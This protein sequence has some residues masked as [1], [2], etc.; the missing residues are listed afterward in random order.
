MQGLRLLG[1]R[2]RRASEQWVDGENFR[3]LGTGVDGQETGLPSFHF[4]S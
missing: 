2:A 1:A 3:S 4:Y